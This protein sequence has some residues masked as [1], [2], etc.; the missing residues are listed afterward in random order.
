MLHRII[1]ALLLIAPIALIS[2]AKPTK[3]GTAPA[4]KAPTKTPRQTTID[5]LKLLAADGGAT[6]WGLLDLG[7][8]SFELTGHP[9]WDA[10]ATVRDDGKIA[11]TWT[12]KSD[13]EI[14]PGLYSVEPDGSMTGCWGRGHEVRFEDNGELTGNVRAD[15]VYRLPPPM[16]PEF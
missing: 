6:N 7:N 1:I 16:G 13:G 2:D 15:R 10:I 4:P 11:V 5:R 9:T 14:C 8:P 12:L 3:P